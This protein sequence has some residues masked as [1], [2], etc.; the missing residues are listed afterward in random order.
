MGSWESR[1]TGG[2]RIQSTDV[3]A[4]S[5]G[6]TYRMWKVK[7]A[8][9]NVPLGLQPHVLLVLSIPLAAQDQN[10]SDANKASATAAGLSAEQLS[11]ASNLLADRALGSSLK[12]THQSTRTGRSMPALAVGVRTFTP[13]FIEGSRGHASPLTVSTVSLGSAN[14]RNRQ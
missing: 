11:K 13:R 7:F 9:R 1:S 6:L 14:R 5:V 8:S 10:S 4:T 3:T 12:Q 2:L